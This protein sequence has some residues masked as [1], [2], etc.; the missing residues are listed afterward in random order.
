MPILSIPPELTLSRSGQEIKKTPQEIILKAINQFIE[1]KQQ[2][3]GSH[4]AQKGKFKYSRSWDYLLQFKSLIENA[5]WEL[6][7]EEELR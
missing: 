2:G 5:V 3:Y 4:P 7:G 1:D 6:L